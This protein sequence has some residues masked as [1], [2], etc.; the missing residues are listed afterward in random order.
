MTGGDV[1][2]RNDAYDTKNPEDVL[3]DK[4]RRVG[5]DDDGSMKGSPPGLLG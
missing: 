1:P 2:W 5:G 3:S 4:V